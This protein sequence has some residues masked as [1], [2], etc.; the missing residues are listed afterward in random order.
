MDG[1]DKLPLLMI[2]KSKCTRCFPKNLSTLP[3]TYRNSS[4]AWMR[5]LIFEKWLKEWNSQ[6]CAKQRHICLL[7]DNCSAHPVDIELTNI[8]YK[9]LPPNTTSLIQPM[10]QGVI[11]N[12]KGHYQSSLNSR[13][14]ASLDADEESNAQSIIKTITLLDA[15][16]LIAE[17]WNNV[18]ISTIANCFRRAGLKKDE[19]VG[20]TDA[21]LDVPI[22]PGVTQDEFE[23]LCDN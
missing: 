4:N 19:V 1:T 18:K 5:S 14:I 21:L 20:D 13:V 7:V 10:D 11:K 6:L 9:F 2:G 12:L 16:H 15:V 3:L 8:T 22:P 17:A 23:T